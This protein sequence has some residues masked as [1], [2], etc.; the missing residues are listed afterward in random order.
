MIAKEVLM[1]FLF[2]INYLGCIKYMKVL[3]PKCLISQIWL[4]GNLI[5]HGWWKFKYLSNILSLGFLRV[6]Q[7]AAQLGIATWIWVMF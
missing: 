2:L 6:F 5:A 4:F 3:D 1:S 7:V